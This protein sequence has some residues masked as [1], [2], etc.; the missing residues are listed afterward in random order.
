M[1]NKTLT[2]KLGIRR[3]RVSIQFIGVSRDDRGIRKL[4]PQLF[5]GLDQIARRRGLGS[6]LRSNRNNV[7]DGFWW[8]HVR[9][10]SI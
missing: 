7:G 1:T 4:L 10:T 5:E 6:N 2:D 8:C 9:R 3:L